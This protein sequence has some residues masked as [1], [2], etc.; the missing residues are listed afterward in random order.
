MPIR[1]KIFLAA[2]FGL[3]LGLSYPPFPTGFLAFFAFTPLFA[4]I[5]STEQPGQVFRLSYAG[6]FIFNLITLYWPGGFVHGKDLYLMTAGASLLIAHPLFFFIPVYLFTAARK[7]L[8]FETSLLLFPVFWV[9]F[10]YVH[11][12]T[13]LAFPWLLLGNTQSYDLSALQFSSLTGVYG[14]SFW[15]V[16]INV[17]SYSIYANLRRK[18]WQLADWKPPIAIAGVVVLY[19]LPKLYGHEVLKN[20]SDAGSPSVRIGIVQPNIDP[21]E[22]WEGKPDPQ[23]SIL[24][25]MTADVARSRPDLILW[26]ETAVP[27]YLSEPRHSV[28]LAMI[29]QQVDTLN[30]NLLTGVPEIVRYPDQASAP[31]G[32]KAFSDGTAYETFNACMLFTPDSGEIQKYAKMLLVP[33]AERVPFSDLLTGL[34]A[35]KWNFGLGGWNVGRSQTLFAINLA[36][37]STGGRE[38]KFST[39]ICY[40][41]IFPGFV[42]GFV[43]EGAEFLTVITND[44]WWGNTSGPYQHIEIGILRAIENRR[45]VVQCSNGGISGFVDPSGHLHEATTMFARGVAVADIA[46]HKELTFYTTFGDWFAQICSIIT[47]LL[48]LGFFGKY[49]YSRSIR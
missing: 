37:K 3:M 26:P 8:G 17:L 11:S 30:V 38:I 15:I 20:Y 44:S 34:N 16:S 48:M 21:F 32:S 36:G 22:K 13:Q 5:E 6:F 23:L 33:F 47:L 18:R 28:Q 19:L 27:Y 9:S 45:W 29:K 7:R 41:S 14:V 24:Q 25:G 40:E 39:L 42:A 49:V 10:E 1:Q 12:V 4:L 43:R 35:A 46:A 31:L 2:L